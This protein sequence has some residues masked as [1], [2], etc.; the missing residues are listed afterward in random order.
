MQVHGGYLTLEREGRE[1]LTVGTRLQ[2][3]DKLPTR[4]EQHAE[5]TD[6]PLAVEQQRKL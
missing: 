2:Q 3:S 4:G 5:P 6:L 1:I